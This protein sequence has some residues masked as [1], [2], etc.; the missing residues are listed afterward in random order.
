MKFFEQKMSAIRLFITGCEYHSS[1]KAFLFSLYNV[2]GYA[3]VKLNIK[4][5]DT[6]IAIY[7]CADR[8][9]DFGGNDLVY[10]TTT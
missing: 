6:M 1:R 10:E 7:S 2:N 5:S 8:G 4:P 3:P 9:P